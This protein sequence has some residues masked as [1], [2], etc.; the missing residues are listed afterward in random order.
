MEGY[1]DFDD[2]LSQL[3]AELNT[4]DAFGGPATKEKFE[5]FVKMCP[6]Y[7]ITGA[8]HKT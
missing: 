6:W 8:I 7:E 5:K 2:Y 1:D 3:E 4:K